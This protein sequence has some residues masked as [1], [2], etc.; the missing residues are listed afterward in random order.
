MLTMSPPQSHSHGGDLETR[1][2]RAGRARFCHSLGGRHQAKCVIYNYAFG[3]HVAPMLQL[4]TRVSRCMPAFILARTQLVMPLTPRFNSS[5]ETN[6]CS[7]SARTLSCSPATAR[8]RMP[9]RHC[10]GSCRRPGFLVAK[11]TPTDRRTAHSAL[12]APPPSQLALFASDEFDVTAAKGARRGARRRTCACRSTQR[13]PPLHKRFVAT[14]Q[15][16]TVEALDQWHK[17]R[18]FVE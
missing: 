6:V 8:R 4:F 15:Q 16:R 9:I 3:L 14:T 2:Q 7:V 18:H 10:T 5:R 1:C 11:S 12:D 13:P 17:Q